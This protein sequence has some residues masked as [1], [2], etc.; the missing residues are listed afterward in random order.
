MAGLLPTGTVTLLLADVEGS[1][2]LWSTQHDEMTAAVARL[3]RAVA[4]I[5][6]IHGGVRPVE[7]GEGDSFVAA[8]ARATDAVACAL[9][10][11]S[12][13]LAPIRLRIGLHTGEV[14][15]RDE[16]NYVGPTVNRTARLRDLAHGG[17]TVLSAA[18]EQMVVDWLPTDAWLTDLGAHKLRD[19]PRPER[20][21]QLCHPD[22]SND[23]PP[24]RTAD[25]VA[26]EHLPVQL[27]KFVGREEQ[28][29]Q[30]RAILAGERLVTLTGAGGAGKTRLAVHVASQIATEFPDGVWYRRLR[31][32]HSPGHGADDGGAHIRIARSAR[33]L[34]D[35]GA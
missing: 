8:F 31:A 33:P 30:V 1:T 14:E 29:A 15:L 3:D 11:Q 32:D 23:F 16:G 2:R 20:V 26:V 35:R 13:P 17:Q 34:D 21:M 9:D 10:L 28:I 5:V 18:T 25:T 4:E 6:A 12:A 27:T 22:L 7:Q 19:V 24:L